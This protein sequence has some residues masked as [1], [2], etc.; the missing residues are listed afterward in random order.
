MTR[1]EVATLA[2]RAVQLLQNRIIDGQNV[3]HA[4]IDAAKKLLS[5]YGTELKLVER[6]VDAL[7]QEADTTSKTVASQSAQIN[8][9]N[10]N[11][12]RFFVRVF[13]VARTFTYAGNV[14]A[15]C[16]PGSYAPGAAGSVQAYCATN[17]GGN[18]LLPGVKTAAFGTYNGPA[19]NSQTLPKWA[20]Q[21]GHGIQ[22]SKS[23]HV[24]NAECEYR[25]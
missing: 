16:G 9:L 6:R 21:S 8:A 22:L 4:D 12:K 18:A 13:D 15:N 1:L 24:G 25:L 3:E 5:E 14:N 2:Y 19:P 10:D 11:S 23:R 20:A 7:Q 17:G